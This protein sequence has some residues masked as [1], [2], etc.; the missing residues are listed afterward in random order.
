MS[1]DI[2]DV[3]MDAFQRDLWI[4]WEHGGVQMGDLQLHMSKLL[5]SDGCPTEGI[6]DAH[7]HPGTTTQMDTK[8]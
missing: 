3:Q 1:V 4:A 8:S 5:G 7:E 6:V 2:S